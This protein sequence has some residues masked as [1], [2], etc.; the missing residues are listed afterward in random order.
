MPKN[1]VVASLAAIAAAACAV[2]AFLSCDLI[3]AAQTYSPNYPYRLQAN[4]AYGGGFGTEYY[5]P[6]TPRGTVR[7]PRPSVMPS[8][9]DP[10]YSSAQG[11]DDEVDLSQTTR[12]T[13]M[14]PTGEGPGAITINTAQRKLYLSLG[15]GRAIE[16]YPISER[17]SW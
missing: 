15:G 5:L 9:A 3:A 7:S 13:V 14:D 16:L 1:P 12:R 8:D 4:P 2:A 6:G 10:A 11:F 17:E